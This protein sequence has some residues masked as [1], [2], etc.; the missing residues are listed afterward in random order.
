MNNERLEFLG[1]AILS[2]IIADILFHRFKKKREGFLTNTRSKIVQRE[3]L[4]RIALEMGLNK[5]IFSS[6]K[7]N[8]HNN[9][10]CGNALEALIG[11]I[12]LDK[13]YAKCKKFI[14]RKILDRFLNV[15]SVAKKVGSV[16]TANIVMLGAATP[17]IG[18]SYEKIAEGIRS[19]FARKGDETVEKNLMALAAGYDVS[20]TN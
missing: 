15:E 10:I 17:F 12:Y 6:I 18:I 19:I 2:A 13:G 5:L 9:Y 1:D 16:L 11:A 14:E 3:S 4:N 20:I 7:T 8:T